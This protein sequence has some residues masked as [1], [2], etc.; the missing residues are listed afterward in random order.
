VDAEAWL[1]ARQ[2]EIRRGTWKPPLALQAEHFGEYAAAWVTTRRN[3][4]GDP[5][6]P[7]TQAD[8]RYDLAHGLA[9]FAGCRL[10]DVTPAMVRR[11]HANRTAESGASSAA[12]EARRLHAILA[13]ACDDELIARNPVA[14][15]LCRSETG[16]EHRP[17]TPDELAAILADMTA[18]APRFRLAVELAAFGGLRL[19]EWRGLRRAEVTKT[20]AGRYAVNVVTQAQRVSGE[21]VTG[22]PKSDEGVRT[23]ALPEWLSADVAEHLANYTD[24][25]TPACLLFPSGGVGE[26]VDQA[27]RRA[28]D[29]ARRA[30][31]VYPV[32]REH[33]LRHYYGSKLAEAGLGIK[34]LQSA[35]GHGTA[36]AS[37]GY[38]HAANGADEATA[39]LLKPLP[40]PEPGNVIPLPKAV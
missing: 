16:L 29:H 20:T 25:Q 11:W 21:W 3:R 26:Y 10:S 22:D 12:R 19:S 14:P 23:V 30:A 37:L 15:E 36:A 31:G 9:L 33:D 17:P 5:L 40:M 1:T 27:W 8:A 4:H 7:K 2:D 38:L 6:R 24:G 39:D 34:Q 32:V 13:T 28:W 35:L 18:N